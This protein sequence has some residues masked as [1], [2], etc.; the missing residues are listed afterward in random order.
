MVTDTPAPLSP[1][2]LPTVPALTS[3]P[4]P[5]TFYVAVDGSDEE[6]DG[7]AVAPWAS[8]SSAV[9]RVP[10]GA[11]ILVQ[12]GTYSGQVDLGG[13]FP[14][15][16][17]VRSALPYRARLEND[18]T[19]VVCFTC[20]GITLE[21]FEITHDGQGAGR[22]V[23][24]IQDVEG[25]GWGGRDV[26]LRDNVIHDSHNN[27]L[28][29]VNNGA[30]NVRLSGNVFYN[31][32][33]PGRDSHLDINSATHVVVENNIF[34]NDF[35]GSGRRNGNDTGSFVVIKDSNGEDDANI[36][37]RNITVR[38]NVFLNWQ[39]GGGNTFIVVGEDSVDYFQAQ[40][41]LI[42]NNLMLGNAPYEIQAAFQVRGSRHV[43]FRNNTV[44][45]DLPGR[46]FAMRL[47]RSD[48]NPRNEAVLFFNNIWSDPT[49][50][51][52]ARAGGGALSF[53]DAEPEDTASFLLRNNLYWN[54][55]RPVPI[56]DHSLVT[57]ADD[58]AAL[59]G[60]PQLPSLH[61]IALPRWLAERG[62]FADG[63]ATIRDAFERL[64]SWYG[65]PAAGSL[66]IDA[67]DPAHVPAE[68][69]LGRPRDDGAPDVGAVERI[70]LR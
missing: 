2:P 60:D 10:D 19:V 6:G 58:P 18:A 32:G 15:G 5:P 12:P 39:G 24:Q 3:T 35:E 40:S 17:T 57:I 36:G 13:R 38:Q 53:A 46:T 4:V 20:A 9:T 48:G 42:E 59:V 31:M 55:N 47:S 43:V 29:K 7:S 66:A 45:G 33:G 68:D 62:V 27:D 26:V 65:T 54:G 28:V 41:V 69:I 30:A 16:L 14:R 23:I 61:D 49:G 64:V 70:P 1:T 67:A 25:N 44:S 34:F 37:A 11:L 51:M 56:D 21:G 50:T 63:S 8:I 52:G 22:Y